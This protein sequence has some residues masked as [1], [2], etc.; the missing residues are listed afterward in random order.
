MSTS[1]ID[2][3]YKFYAYRWDASY[4]PQMHSKY[5]VVDGNKLYSGSYNLSDNSDH[6]TFEN[7]LLLEAPT[8][9]KLI[10]AFEVNFES[11]WK[12]G[13]DEGRL[14]ALDTRIDQGGAFPI[15]FDPVALSSDEVTALKDKIRTKCPAVD[16]DAFR[17]AATSHRVC[18]P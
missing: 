15:V 6:G 7:E 1:G 4:A 17:S 18:A 11:I 12:T 8:H 3:R 10:S 5:M 14:A 16:S 13:R 2:V 9:A